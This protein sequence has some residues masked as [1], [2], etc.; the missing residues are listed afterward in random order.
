MTNT[1]VS[2]IIPLAVLQAV[3]TLDQ[4]GPERMVQ[5]HDEVAPKRLGMNPTVTAQIERYRQLAQRN[6]VV[7]ADE[8]VQLFRLVGRRGDANLAFSQGGRLA[9]QHALQQT[10]APLKIASKMAPGPVKRRMG[11]RSA[12][13]LAASVFGS[14]VTVD[15]QDGVVAVAQPATTEATP[16]G[17]SCSFYGS[18]LA[19]ILRST[20]NFDGAL[21]HETCM[22]RGGDCCRWHTGNNQGW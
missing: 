11:L 21:L 7:D 1:Q 6:G 14:T 9:A 5:Y 19:E 3:R 15:E 16:D 10:P 22:T 18:A 4:Q 13:R 2:A 17:A 8:V 12:T 20:T